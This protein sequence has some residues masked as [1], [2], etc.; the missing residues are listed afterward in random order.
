VCFRGEV[1]VTHGHDELLHSITAAARDVFGAAAC[2]VAV[3]EADDEHLLFRAAAGTGSDRIVGRRLPVGRGIAGWAAS[4]G[5]AI[6][7]EN[8]EG[9]PRF[10]R[11]TAE[12]TGFVPRSIMAAPL[13][14]D[15]RL[16]GVIE[17]LDRDATTQSRQPG[18]D[19][20]TR[21]AHQAALVLQLEQGSGA[22]AAGPPEPADPAALD[23][24]VAELS[25]MGVEERR[26]AA[27][28]LDA[29]LAYA[30]RRRGPAGLV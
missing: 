6:S 20:L 14:A 30:G 18:L 8:V 27:A 19:L 24:A 12:S 7:V 3:L 10:A 28:I 15:G 29:F 22:A 23:R 9:D 21:F 2:S 26:C 5:E 25:S 17:V 11:D 13:E 4:S 16:Y 1:T